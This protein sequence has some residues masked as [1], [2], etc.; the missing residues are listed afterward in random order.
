MQ[1][2]QQ[3]AEVNQRQ[4]K[5][6]RDHYEQLYEDEKQQLQQLDIQQEQIM[7]E[8]QTLE[9]V[10]S[11]LNYQKQLQTQLLAQQKQQQQHND[12]CRQDMVTELS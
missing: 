11:D 10:T 8:E 2:I 4:M 7:E 12:T 5:V 3:Q 9:R 1:V 6:E